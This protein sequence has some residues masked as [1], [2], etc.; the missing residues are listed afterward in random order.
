MR[1]EVER[2]IDVDGAAFASFV[3]AVLNDPRSW[4][5]DGSIGFARTDGAAP[6][7]VVLATPELADRLCSPLETVGSLSCRNGDQVVLN[8]GRWTHGTPE[9]AR[10]LTAYRR[11][12]VNHEVGHWL[13]HP[14]EECPAPG[15][16][17][18]VM[19]QQTLGLKG[20]APNSWPR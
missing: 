14:H 16:P 17:A 3:A 5:G 4:G 1:V 7:R 2:G 10:D 13:G 12:L 6:L 15:R 8:L 11:Y 18:P 19:Q 20:C 9:Y